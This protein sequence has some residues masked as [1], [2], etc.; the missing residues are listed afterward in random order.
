[1]KMQQAIREARNSARNGWVAFVEKGNDGEW[2]SFG[3]L[4]DTW[5]HAQH[6]SRYLV[7]ASETL[8]GAESRIRRLHMG[9][10]KAARIYI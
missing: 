4:R 7:G 2:R 1:M 5:R 9:D 10:P 3:Y 8:A 6:E